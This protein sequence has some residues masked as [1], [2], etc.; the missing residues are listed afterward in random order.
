MPELMTIEELEKYLRFTRKTIYKLLKDGEIPA[1]K[2][3]NKWRFDKEEID[4]W[5]R[6]S[7]NGNKK[8]ILVIDD[9]EMMLD[10]FKET[11]EEAGHIV[12]TAS[13]GTEGIACVTRLD[14]DLIFL[15]LKLP[16]IDGAETLREM[17]NVK[18]KL[19]VIIITGYPDSE[20][21]EQAIKQGPLAVIS[22]PFNDID[23]INAVNSFCMIE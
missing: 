20:L 10:I 13:N 23:I 6:Q 8:R 16:G 11:L 4:G 7:S 12:Q 1:I 15:D 17:R 5:L 3:G 9:E 2:I 18:K 22:K 19:P 21:M 14:F